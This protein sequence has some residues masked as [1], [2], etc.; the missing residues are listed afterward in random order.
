MQSPPPLSSGFIV[1]SDPFGH[2]FIFLLKTTYE[3][4]SWTHP[5]PLHLFR[6]DY[7]QAGRFLSQGVIGH[8]YVGALSAPRPS[9]ALVSVSMLH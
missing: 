9:N 8:E 5:L 1:I 7:S 3:K 6:M 4:N 2:D